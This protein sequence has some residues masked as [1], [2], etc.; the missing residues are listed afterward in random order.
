MKKFNEN[1]RN[2]VRNRKNNARARLENSELALKINAERKQE[3]IQKYGKYYD[4][5]LAGE[6]DR[7]K[8]LPPQKMDDTTKQ[9]SYDY[10]Y[11]ERGSRVL[12]GLF[13]AGT[14]TEQEQRNLGI[15]DII[16]G[17]SEK[18]TGNLKKYNAYMNGRNY[19]K[20][21]EAYTFITENNIS[22]E[23]YAQMMEILFPEVN[24][25]SFKEGYNSKLIEIENTNHKSK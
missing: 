6:K 1:N 12:E 21:R 14:F 17:V 10:G 15:A 23:E 13:A 7:V 11:Y 8:G 9:T 2:Y 22:Y 5:L 24:D 18:N 25:P 3:Y 20:G 4:L 19:Q 16:N